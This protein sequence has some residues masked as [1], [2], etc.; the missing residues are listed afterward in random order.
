MLKK[1]SAM[2]IAITM[3]ISSVY[4]T[5]LNVEAATNTVK[6]KNV[7]VNKK[8]IYVGSS[9]ALKI[10]KKNVTYSSNKP[11]IVTVNEDGIM[12]ARKKGKAT[13]TVKAGDGK[14]TK[15]KVKVKKAERYKIN[16]KAGTYSSTVKVKLKAKKGYKIYYTTSK[17]FKKKNVVKSGQTKTIKIRKTKTLSIYVVKKNEKFSKK[18]NKASQRKKYAYYVQYKYTINKNKSENISSENTGGEDSKNQN[19]NKSEVQ[20]ETQDKINNA[21]EEANKENN[22]EIIQT[23]STIDTD[24]PYVVF[25]D[26][27]ISTGN[28]SEEEITYDDGSVPKI[29]TINKAGTYWLSG[30]TTEKPIENLQIKIKKNIEDEVN[31]IW[32]GLVIDNSSLGNEDEHDEAVFSVGKSTT[33]VNVTLKGQSELVGNGSYSSEPAKAIISAGDAGTTVTFMAYE[34]DESAGLTVI[35]SMAASIDYDDNEPSDGI[36]SKGTLI[37]NGGNYT[38]ISNGDCLKGTGKDGDGGII[39]NGGNFSLESN[40]GN[41]LKSKNGNININA[42]TINSEYTAEDGINAKKYDVIISGGI[43]N[44][45]NCHGDGIQGENVNISGDSTVINIKTYFLNAGKNYYNSSLGSGNYNTM[46]VTN[47]SKTE[48]VNIDTGSHKGIKGGT[49]ACTFS[50]ASVEEDS[51]YTAGTTYTAEASGG[52]VISGGTIT[53]DT[54]NTG[55][56]YN[57]GRSMGGNMR[58]GQSSSSSGNLSAANNDGQYIIGSPDDAIHSNNTCTIAGGTIDIYSSDDGITAATSMLLINGCNIKINQCYEGIE[59]KEIIVGSAES[60]TEEP[61]IKIYSND[62]GVNASSKTVDYEY[63]DETE[64][65]CTKKTYSSSTG[66]TL[67]VLAGYLNVMIGDDETHSFSLPVE[68]GS[69]TTSTYSSNGDGIDCNGTFYAYGGTIIVYGAT[70]G[71]NSPIDTDDTYHIGSGT[72]ILAVGGGM[73]TNPTSKEQPVVTK[74]SSGNIGGNMRPGQSNATSSLSAFA[75]MEGSNIVLAINPVKNYSYVLY[76]SPK[77]K[78]GTAYTLYSGGSVRGT[79]INLDT[80]AFDY[81]YTGYN[82]SGATSSTVTAN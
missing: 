45:D 71:D 20:I 34:G 72:T 33:V 31:L 43:I 35:D 60:I 38:I 49:K 13:I 79:L 12:Y 77:L 46:T 64:E 11:A 16:K 48:I 15:I 22:S 75:I 40:L 36:Y 59:G 44:I 51:D 67:R 55:I 26:K 9:F 27:G 21:T 2:I 82:T 4:I 17:N 41:A 62:D 42:G 78:S 74:I 10:N 25:T 70:S 19:T 32:D 56:K 5:P 6:V 24:T 52:I 28:M 7:N 57:G 23:P 80:E 37:I 58:P 54:T 29:L 53:I 47:T 66:C 30:G 69:V 68:N 39:I 1:I 61:N 3:M 14:K 76:S 81:R 65:Q 50:Y 8:I 63:V 18:M 73:V